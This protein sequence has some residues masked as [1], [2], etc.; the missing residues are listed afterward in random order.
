[1]NASAFNFD[2]EIDRRAVPAL[3]AHTIVL[4]RGGEHLFPN[5]VKR[6]SIQSF[7]LRSLRVYGVS[8]PVCLFAL[9]P[10][11]LA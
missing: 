3:K 8:A 7:S 2:E 5:P 11:H 1:M 4:G 9:V 10:L 6:F